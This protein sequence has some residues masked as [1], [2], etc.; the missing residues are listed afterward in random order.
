MGEGGGGSDSE[1]EQPGDSDL[2]LHE[3]VFLIKVPEIV[4]RKNGD[5]KGKLGVMYYAYQK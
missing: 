4:R 5:V 2:F 1:E 3:E